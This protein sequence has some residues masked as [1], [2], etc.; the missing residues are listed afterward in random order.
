MV[1]EQC[2]ITT[3]LNIRCGE[4]WHPCNSGGSRAVDLS[5]NVI[6]AGNSGIV[7]NN[8]A[9]GFISKIG[10]NQISLFPGTPVAGISLNMCRRQEVTG[11]TVEVLEDGTYYHGLRLQSS[12]DNFIYGNHFLDCSLGLG[13]YGSSNNYIY[14]NEAVAQ[15]FFNGSDRIREQQ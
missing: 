15:T 10:D 2:T 12:Q 9:S 13:T 5:N 14:E 11:N 4:P 3:L 1:V 6:R 7:V 8:Y